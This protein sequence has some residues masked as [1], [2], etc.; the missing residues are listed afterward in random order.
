MDR[1]PLPVSNC[2]VSI[3]CLFFSVYDGV[4]IQNYETEKSITI[5]GSAEM[6]W[7]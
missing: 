1:R 2:V 7:G 3:V 4:I 6:I 5:K